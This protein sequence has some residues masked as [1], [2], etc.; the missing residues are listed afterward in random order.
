MNESK[1][2]SEYMRTAWISK[3]RPAKSY[4]VAPGHIC[5]LCIER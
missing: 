5:K 2:Y 3:P 1:C 4:Y